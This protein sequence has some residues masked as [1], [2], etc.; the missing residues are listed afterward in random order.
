MSSLCSL[1]REGRACLVTSFNV[2]KYMIL[3]ATTQL[4][5][6]HMTVWVGTDTN[7]LHTNM[8]TNITSVY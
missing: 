8:D 4:V 7:L 6:I 2:F 1:C 3:Y 5:A